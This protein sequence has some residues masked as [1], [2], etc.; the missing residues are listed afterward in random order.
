M[1]KI[2]YIQKQNEDKEI[3][4]SLNY[5]VGKWFK[6]KFEKFSDAQRY[7][8]INIK[9]RKNIL[10]SSPTGSGKTLCAFG[11]ILNYLMLGHIPP[12]KMGNTLGSVRGP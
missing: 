2:E 7:S 4:D 10:V 1:G 3:F 5:I 11:S 9:D 6:E 12:T 8:M